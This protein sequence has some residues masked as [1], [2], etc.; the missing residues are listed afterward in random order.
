MWRQT[1]SKQH[2]GNLQQPPDRCQVGFKRPE[3]QRTVLPRVASCPEISYAASLWSDLKTG[4]SVLKDTPSKTESRLGGVGNVLNLPFKCG[5][6]F[7]RAR[8]CVRAWV[9]A[10]TLCLVSG[11]CHVWL[12]DS[13]F[14]NS[15]W[16]LTMK[17]WPE[18]QKICPTTRLFYSYSSS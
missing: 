2:R 1:A 17:T 18:S 3:A 11:I 13:L 9:C 8:V 15:R 5:V 6:L 16:R 14:S 10:A 4:T 7:V 12:K